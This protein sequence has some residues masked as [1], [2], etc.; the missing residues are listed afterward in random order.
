MSNAH[1][2]SLNSSD[3]VTYTALPV[4][5]PSTTTT[6]YTSHPDVPSQ[7]QVQ[8]K[9]IIM[10]FQY[11]QALPPAQLAQLIQGNSEL[12]NLFQSAVASGK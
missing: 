1:A 2:Q 12:R 4:P 3:P 7:S 6:P 8:P 10:D 5:A 9:A 11:L